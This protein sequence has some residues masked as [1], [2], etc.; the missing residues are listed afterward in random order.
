[1]TIPKLSIPKRN[2]ISTFH[3]PAGNMDSSKTLQLHIQTLPLEIKTLIS[4]WTVQV[5]K[6]IQSSRRSPTRSDAVLKHGD[7]PVLL[8]AETAN[9]I[10]NPLELF[11]ADTELAKIA[12]EEFWKVNLFEVYSSHWFG[13]N[14]SPFSQHSGLLLDE[15]SRRP[16][17][18][19]LVLYVGTG[20]HCNRMEEGI[21]GIIGI[22]EVNVLWQLA[23]AY[24]KLQSLMIEMDYTVNEDCPSWW[25]DPEPNYAI[26]WES[27]HCK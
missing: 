24:P 27:E 4:R 25:P 3:Q 11:S 16:Y 10:S 9:P 20:N 23:S 21:E 12:L 6:T 19:H 18:Q 5:S 17:I 26:A 15:T 7:I 14:D 22:N 2:K 1:L 13:D 8:D